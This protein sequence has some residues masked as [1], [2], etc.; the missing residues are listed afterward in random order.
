MTSR[1]SADAGVL[2]VKW[3]SRLFKKH[4]RID[5]I[6]EISEDPRYILIYTVD[7][8]IIRLRV[9]LMDHDKRQAARKFL[10]EVTGF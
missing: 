8:E 6:K 9:K 10:K 2:T 1:I 5:K 3:Y 7:G 4:I